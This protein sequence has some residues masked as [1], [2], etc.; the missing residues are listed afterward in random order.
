MITDELKEFLESGVGAM[1]GTHSAEL[2]P[3]MTR[4]WGPRVAEDGCTVEVCISVTA[5][6]RTLE[7]LADNRRIALTCGSPID[8]KQVQFK[9]RCVEIVGPRQDDLARVEHH[10]DQFARACESIG[11]PRQFIESLYRYDVA[12]PPVLIKIRFEPQEFFNQT[13]GPGAGSTL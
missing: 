5:G 3:E 11:T 6:K 8:Y 9:G 2:V 12:D 7:N 1:I 4:G 10:V 13:P